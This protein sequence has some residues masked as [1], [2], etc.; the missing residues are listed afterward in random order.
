MRRFFCILAA[1]L[2]VVMLA[3]CFGF[4]KSAFSVGDKVA[5]IEIKGMIMEPDDVIE[6]FED[7]RK[8]SNYKAVV[9]RVDSPGGTVAASQEIFR[10]IKRLAGEK[11][12][13]ISMGDVAA[14]GGYYVSAG[15]SKI[16]AN[17]GTITGSIGVRLELMNAAQ[18]FKLMRLEPETLKSGKFKDL[19]S[20]YRAMSPEE[21]KILQD[22]LTELHDQFK[23]DVGES[24]GLE[25][26]YINELADGRVFTGQKAKELGLVDEIGGLVEASK[27]AAKMAGIKGEP[28]VVKV[29]KEKP[30][31]VSMFEEKAGLLIREMSARVL[32]NKYFLYEWKPF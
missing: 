18:L 16:F 8:E 10:E 9:V 28:N 32:G 7:A 17:E 19:G 1:L 4:K 21:R 3:G 27:E 26:S 15:G 12:V 29:R 2:T 22:F 30:W 14:S 6:D 31:W 24:R 11:P 25:L 13:V 23:K 20:V 5:L